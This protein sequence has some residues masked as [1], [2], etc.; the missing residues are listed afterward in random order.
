MWE[1]NNQ[2]NPYQY[3]NAQVQQILISRIL[4]FMVYWELSILFSF[5]S[6]IDAHTGGK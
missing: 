4:C 5:A 6:C 1:Y 3:N 2:A